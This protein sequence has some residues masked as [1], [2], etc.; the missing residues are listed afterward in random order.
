LNKIDTIDLNQ[1]GVQTVGNYC[2]PLTGDCYSDD[3]KEK[4]METKI[5]PVCKMEVK[6]EGAQFV[7]E[8]AG[9]NY[10]FCSAGCQH[11]FEEHP[12]S[13]AVSTKKA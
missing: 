2:D 9:E 1:L 11:E 4:I 3:A 5:D 6:V 13:Y 8:Y 10:Y 7:S 12:E